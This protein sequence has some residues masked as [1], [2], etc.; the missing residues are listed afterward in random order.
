MDGCVLRSEETRDPPSPVILGL[1]EA[2]N[3]GSIF[4]G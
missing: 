3:P 4:N 1:R 2:Q